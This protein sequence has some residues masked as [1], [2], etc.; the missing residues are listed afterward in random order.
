MKFFTHLFFVFYTTGFFA[1][2]NNSIISDRPCQANSAFSLG[3]GVVQFQQGL[4]FYSAN[5]SSTNVTTIMNENVIRAGI[6]DLSEISALI[7]MQKDTHD[8]TDTAYSTS[9]LSQLHLGFRTHVLD[10]NKFI[11]NTCF[12]V[13][14]KIPDV[15]KDYGIPFLAPQILISNNWTLPKGFGITTNYLASWNGSNPTP[16]GAY[17]F[18]LSYSIS[19]KLGIAIENYG[20]IEGD[21]FNT[22]LDGGLTYLLNNNTQLDLYGGISDNS[23][24]KISFVSMGVSWRLVPKRLKA[25]IVKP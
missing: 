24:M 15:S 22:F 14:F 20:N 4:D 9:G 10:Q 25:P 7:T 5:F 16:T 2:Y 13:R 23:G 8:F 12:Q 18:N 3:K 17:V 11:P 21:T 19:D 6:S 1:Q